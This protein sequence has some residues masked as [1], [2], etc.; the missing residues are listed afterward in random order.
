MGGCS[1]CCPHTD[2][3]PGF[4]FHGCMAGLVR[5]RKKGL[6]SSFPQ[7]SLHLAPCLSRSCFYSLPRS[8]QSQRHDV[9]FPERSQSPIAAAPRHAREP[10]LQGD[11]GFSTSFSHPAF[12]LVRGFVSNTTPPLERQGLRASI[13]WSLWERHEVVNTVR[14]ANR[15]TEAS[16]T[17][18]LPKPSVTKHPRA[19]WSNQA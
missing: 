7:T 8:V 5:P 6:S 4:S 13:L 15:H 9:P 19:I 14:H 16:S 2:H 10:G 3:L 12:T 11:C 18:P 17:S 1:V